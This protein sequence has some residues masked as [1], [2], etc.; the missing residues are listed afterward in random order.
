MANDS[1]MV[2]VSDSFNFETFSEEVTRQYRMKGYQINALQMKGAVKFVI[3]KN[4]GGI[5]TV[6]GMG[7]GITATCT[8]TGKENDMLSVTFTDAEWT[9]KIIACAIGWVVCLIP[10]ITGIVGISRQSS[11]SKNLTNDLQLIANNL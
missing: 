4:L 2:N 5:N 11:L 9:S 10:F 6:L 3:S 8:L 7:E 1:F